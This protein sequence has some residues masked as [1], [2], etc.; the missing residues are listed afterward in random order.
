MLFFMLLLGSWFLHLAI[1]YMRISCEV[2]TEIIS[3][4]ACEKQTHINRKED[5]LGRFR[6]G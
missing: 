5:E 1:A 6:T 4:E 3:V 2:L